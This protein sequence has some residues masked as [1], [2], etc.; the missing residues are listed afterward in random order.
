[1]FLTI[2]GK[3]LEET[4]TNK[5]YS[6]SIPVQMLSGLGKELSNAQQTKLPLWCRRPFLTRVVFPIM[7]KG[8]EGGEKRRNRHKEWTAAPDYI[9]H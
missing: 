3:Y 8:K 9:Q 4:Q 1:M 7:I 2:H 5:F 6:F